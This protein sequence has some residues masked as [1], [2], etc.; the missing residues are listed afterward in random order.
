MKKL[1]YVLGLVTLLLLTSS[2]KEEVFF[3]EAMPSDGEHLCCIPE[4]LHG[5][6]YFVSDSSL[7]FVSKNLVTTETTIKYKTT[8]KRVL[9]SENCSLKDGGLH[10][11]GRKECFPFEYITEDTL[12]VTI[13]EIDTLFK[14]TPASKI[15]QRDNALF[16]NFNEENLGWITYIFEEQPDRTI[17]FSNISIPNKERII[18]SLV[19]KYDKLIDANSDEL[20]RIYPTDKEFNKILNSKY[21]RKQDELKLFNF[22]VNKIDY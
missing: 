18:K 10:L 14:F 7:L 15:I 12:L 16:V 6:Y 1:D 9:E 19:K 21:V 2:C 3:N 11:T 5:V 13:S 20:Y 22:E 17:E 8:T 4:N